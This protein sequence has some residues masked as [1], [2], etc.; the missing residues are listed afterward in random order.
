V[1]RRAR[2]SPHRSSRCPRGRRR[3]MQ[4]QAPA[5]AGSRCQK[6]SRHAVIDCGAGGGGSGQQVSGQ[7][8]RTHVCGMC[9]TAT[10]TYR[11][12]CI[13]TSC[14]DELLT[15]PEPPRQLAVCPCRHLCRSSSTST[16]RTRSAVLHELLGLPCPFLRL[17]GGHRLAGGG[18][19]GHAGLGHGGETCPGD[20]GMNEREEGGSDGFNDDARITPLR[21]RTP[22][23]H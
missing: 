12:A 10:I 6:G 20:E 11:H 15:E 22:T 1:R 23:R 3:C 2:F 9:Y 7:K 8:W 5:G 4:L 16:A 18:C 19:G 13:R 17:R 14:G 21:R